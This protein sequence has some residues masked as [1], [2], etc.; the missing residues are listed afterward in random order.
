M[1]V[2]AFSLGAWTASFVPFALLISAAL[3]AAEVAP[4]LDHARMTYAIWATVALAIPPL[5]LQFGARR[6]GE[7]ARLSWTFAYLAYV[8]HFYYAFGVQYH[9]SLTLLYEGQGPAIA[10]A[11]LLFT[12]LWTADIVGVWSMP[13]G[14]G[15]RV[16][17][18]ATRVLFVAEVIMSTLV[19]FSGFVRVLGALLV[20]S[21]VSAAIWAFAHR[22]KRSAQA[23]AS[24]AL[25]G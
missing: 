25:A 8:L 12:V 20:A 2:R 21:V 14:L 22:K 10:T 5:V 15:W 19:I 16:L 4:E 6:D 18:G 3:L 13:R 7:Y 11:N 23:F 24:D 9:W 1:K 17:D